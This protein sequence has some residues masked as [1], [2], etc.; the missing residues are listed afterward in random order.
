MLESPKVPLLSVERKSSRS[1]AN[2]GLTA[3]LML[4]LLLMV[5]SSSHA[6]VQSSERALSQETNAIRHGRDSILLEREEFESNEDEV[7]VGDIPKATEAEKP[8]CDQLRTFTADLSDIPENPPLFGEELEYHNW[9]VKLEKGNFLYTHNGKKKKDGGRG[10]GWGYTAILGLVKHQDKGTII[11]LEGETQN[12]VEA[13]TTALSTNERNLWLCQYELLAKLRNDQESQKT[14]QTA[15]TGLLSQVSNLGK[16][17]GMIQ[18]LSVEYKLQDDGGKAAYDI[19]GVVSQLNFG[20]PIA[21]FDPILVGNPKAS[22]YNDKQRHKFYKN[23][24]PSGLEGLWPL[25]RLSKKGHAADLTKLQMIP[26]PIVRSLTAFWR[27]IH[28]TLMETE[29]KDLAL[30][31]AYWKKKDFKLFPK[32]KFTGSEAIFTAASAAYDALFPGEKY[33]VGHMFKQG[34]PSDVKDQSQWSDY[35]TTIRKDPWAGI[36]INYADEGDTKSIAVAQYGGQ[37]FIVVET[38]GEGPIK[39]L[40]PSTADHKIKFDTPMR[41][42]LAE[43]E[44][45]QSFTSNVQSRCDP[46]PGNPVVVT[47]VE[48]GSNDASKEDDKLD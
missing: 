9:N 20:V 13:M 14:L 48:Q 39:D 45:I 4:G 37:L 3:A 40:L 28:L 6:R 44:K 15:I 8:L 12:R 29:G 36:R 35:G 24:I 2:Y 25:N 42:F 26:D 22:N 46:N 23:R 11:T 1:F 38:R 32:H 33:G 27:E 34:N 41:P 5:A 30:D 31:D 47:V 21:L 19:E 43:M 18:K 7:E 17:Y 10:A 16:C